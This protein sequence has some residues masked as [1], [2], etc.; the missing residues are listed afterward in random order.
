MEMHEYLSELT[1]QIRNKKA[2]QEVEREIRTHI[3]DQAQVYEQMGRTRDEAREEAVRQM[4]SPVEVG[5]DMDR[6]HRP[7]NN[8]MV[9]GMAM[10]L[11]LAGLLVQYFCIYRFGTE[12]LYRINQDAFARQCLYTFLGLGFMSILYFCD[13]SLFSRYGKLI[14]GLFLVSI[15]LVCNLGMVQVINGGHSYMKTVMYL[16]IPMYGGILYGYRGT[17]YSGVIRSL[18][19][20]LAAAYTSFAVIGGGIGIT[21]DVM[22]VCFM[23]L[24]YSLFRNWYQVKRKSRPIL[25]LGA[26]ALAGGC[27]S[28]LGMQPYQMARLRAILSPWAYAREEAFQVVVTR[29]IMKQLKFLGGLTKGG[30]PEGTPIHLLPGAQYDYVM[31]QAASTWGVLAVG[32]LAGLLILFLFLLFHM[33]KKQ[34][35]QLGQ[36]IGY[37]C[38]MILVLET[39]WNLMLN[40]GFV[41]VSTAGLPFFTYGG[42]HTVAVY[43]LLGIL[44]SIY[45]YQDLIWERSPKMKAEDNHVLAQLGRYRIRIEKMDL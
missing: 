26:L 25:G 7:K 28:Y 37:G 27:Y 36:L 41:F 12:N 35:N 44:L 8:W 43:G 11:S 20:L 21:L 10:L 42:Y 40:L 38:V 16:F 13:Y 14:G 17:G 2:K 22:S 33:V 6:I 19:W 34:K 3:E 4:G 39:G 24:M 1:G 23:M 32:I 9:L 5:I 30:T 15:I 18:L 45:R 31:L 29:D